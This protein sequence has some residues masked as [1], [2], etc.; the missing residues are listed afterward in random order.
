MKEIAFVLSSDQIHTKNGI[1]LLSS[2][3]S[4][5]FD[6]L[7]IRDSFCLWSNMTS[8]SDIIAFHSY[9]MALFTHIHSFYCLKYWTKLEDIPSYAISAS[10][11]SSVLCCAV[12]LRRNVLFANYFSLRLLFICTKWKLRAKTHYRILP[13]YARKEIPFRRW[14]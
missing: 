9:H 10:P 13:Y 2:A 1:F 11:I 14:K 8:G 7:C 12:C 5:L 6:T 4:H 3:H